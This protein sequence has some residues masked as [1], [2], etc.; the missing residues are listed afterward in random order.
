MEGESGRKKGGAPTKRL[1][2]TLSKPIALLTV[3]VV[4]AAVTI[5]FYFGYLSRTTTT[6]PQVGRTGG[7]TLPSGFTHSQVVGGLKSPTD[8]EFAPDGKLFVAEQAG[9]LRVVQPDGTLETFLDFSAKVD[10]S[11]ERGLQ[12]LAFD[13]NFSA[14]NRFVYLL[15]TSKGTSTTPAHNRV[16][17]VTARHERTGD[18]GVVAGSEKLIFQLDTQDA[19]NHMGG[20]IDFGED[21]KLYISTG[22]NETPTNSQKLTNLFGKMLRIN[23]DGTIPIKNPFYSRASGN[24]R[25]IWALGLRNPSTFAV[26]PATGTIFVND[27]GEKVWEEINELEKGDNYGWPV[28]EGREGDP[29]Y[30]GPVYAYKHGDTPTRGCSIA[31]GTFYNPATPQPLHLPTEYEGYYFFADFCNDWIRNYDPTTDKA[32]GFAT[33]LERLV[34]LEVSE[35]GQ[36]YYLSKD[37][38]GFVGKIG[39]AG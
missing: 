35:Q 27:E 32:R 8:M 19:T 25:A 2:E 34:D 11:G 39:Y 26:Q 24:N 7:L 31:G 28:H 37:N 33:G 3:V 1:S 22:D 17:R 23:K 12:A 30:R 4:V 15:F 9:K 10:S 29:D 18:N 21:G 38:P 36:L 14:G 20:A 13:P 16:V 6:P 5:F